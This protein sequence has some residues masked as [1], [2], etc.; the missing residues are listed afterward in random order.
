MGCGRDVMYVMYVTYM[1][2]QKN[3]YKYIYI[4]CLNP[5]IQVFL[6]LGLWRCVTKSENIL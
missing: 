2:S 4:C 5:I 6:S 1:H 3:V